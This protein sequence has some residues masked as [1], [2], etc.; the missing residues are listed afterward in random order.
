MA[1]VIGEVVGNISGD[2][3][4][5]EK[6]MDGVKKSG[7]SAM[8]GIEQRF[9][10]LSDDI[11]SR[12]K[13]LSKSV[14]APILAIG[15]ALF[16]ATNRAANFADEIDKMAIRSGVSRQRL[17]ELKFVTDQVGVEFGA[18]EQAVDSFRR[19]LTQVDDGTGRVSAN[20]SRLGVSV[21]DANGELRDMDSLFPEIIAKLSKIENETERSALA[22]DIFGR[23]ASNLAPLLAQ[24]EAGIER[25]TAQ[26]HELGL[27]MGD[28]SIADLV[29]FKDEMAAL[30]QQA[31]AVGRE[32]GMVL[33]PIIRNDLMPLIQNRLIPAIRQAADF[34]NGLNDSTKRTA[35]TIAALAASSGPV[36]M[37]VGA[38]GKLTAAITALTAAMARNPYTAIGV[39][40]L[41]LS[42]Y[43]LSAKKSIS[44]LADELSR[45][46]N[47]NDFIDANAYE[48]AINRIQSKIDE[49]NQS[50]ERY[51]QLQK[52]QEEHVPPDHRV[53]YDQRIGDINREIEALQALMRQYA[54]I[55]QQHIDS[56]AGGDSQ[57]I[58][59]M[60]ASLQSAQRSLVEFND[61]ADKIHDLPSRIFPPGSLGDIRQ[62]IADIN[63][64][65]QYM[66]DPAAIQAMRAEIERLE[67]EMNKLTNQTIR[68]FPPGSLGAIREEIAGINLEMQYLTD[69]LQIEEMQNRIKE[70]T[71]EMAELTGQTRKFGIDSEWAAGQLSKG[72][73]DAV[74]YGKNLQSTLRDIARQLASRVIQQFLMAALTGGTSAVG[75]GGGIGG[76]LFN[77][78][79]NVG[80]A[81][82][83]SNGDVVQFHPN[84]N[85][86]A[87]QGDKMPGSGRAISLMIPITV[88]GRTV[89]EANRNF[90]IDLD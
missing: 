67:E 33:I 69:P 9:K 85:L 43:A 86:V 79:F 36:M 65:M 90:E 23:S 53:E 29:K 12:G 83:R 5:F 57:E 66:T 4:G 72:I 82:V 64:E 71:D 84:D 73:A 22:V 19:R 13:A 35:V 14:T 75:G 54:E 24:G 8:A 56:G 62:Q 50:L 1:I 47:P 18:V 20:L 31:L 51:T 70:L 80:D 61:E 2:S 48:T 44:G 11:T 25:L 45:D 39:G 7:E 16:T 88:D 68:L 41:A 21:R 30:T 89:W 37:A 32:F 34:F 46:I 60:D 63:L 78:I 49:L 76:M 27:V 42:V 40:L 87:F 28:E 26:A 15:A 38:F 77:R 58:L 6:A 81:L 52:D 55:R 17:Q 3:T 10:K 59:R 74:V